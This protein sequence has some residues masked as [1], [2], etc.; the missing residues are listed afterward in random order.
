MTTAKPEITYQPKYDGSMRFTMYFLS[1]L[2]GV[3]RVFSLSMVSG[4]LVQ[5]TGISGSGFWSHDFL[6]AVQ[7]VPG[8][9]FWRQDHR[10]MLSPA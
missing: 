7:S 2:G 4:T 3:D 10:E 9:A 1:G 6:P 5:P 8:S